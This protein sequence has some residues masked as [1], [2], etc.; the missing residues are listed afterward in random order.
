MI[1]GVV[2]LAVPRSSLVVHAST[3]PESRCCDHQL[4]P[5]CAPRARGDGPL[6]SRMAD[7]IGWC[8]PRTRGWS[9][10]QLRRGHPVPVLPAHAGMVPRPRPAT[11]TRPCA[12]R[13]RGDGP[14]CSAPTADSAA[15]SPRTRGWS[16][17]DPV[18]AHAQAVLPAHAGMVPRGCVRWP[19][20]ARAP[21]ARGDGPDGWVRLGT[22]V[23]C[24]PRTRGWSR[25]A[26]ARVPGARVLP[27][28]AGMVPGN[29]PAGAPLLRAPHARGDGSDASARTQDLLGCS[30]RTHRHTTDYCWRGFWSQGPLCGGCCS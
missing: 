5:P 6:L 15:C 3:P 7:R 10:P 25:A 22:Q 2:G 1:V 20:R 12:P 26:A 16:R 19:R 8:S 21:R 4:N 14:S 27:A 11:P 30:P 9:Q 28:H 18:D 29:R 17:P 13:A 23:P 24:S